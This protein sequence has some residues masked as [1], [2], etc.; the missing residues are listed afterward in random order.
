MHRVLLQWDAPY[1]TAFRI[2]LSDDAVTWRQIYTTTTGRGAKQVLSGLDGTGRY[3]RVFGTARSGQ[4]GYSLWELQV[5][6][7]GGA[8]RC[9]AGSAREP[10]AATRQAGLRRRFHGSGGHTT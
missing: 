6:A 2:E 7:T 3:L 1:A 8:L 4:Y 9:P 10:A 5:F